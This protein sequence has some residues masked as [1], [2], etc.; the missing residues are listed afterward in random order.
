M[1]NSD[2]VQRRAPDFLSCCD[3]VPHVLLWRRLPW[4]P[5]LLLKP[6]NYN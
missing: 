3:I 5:S 4:T 2:Q 6:L 1:Q